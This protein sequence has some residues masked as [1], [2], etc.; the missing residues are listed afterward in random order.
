MDALIAAREKHLMLSGQPSRLL[1]NSVIMGNSHCLVQAHALNAQEVFSLR[2]ILQYAH[3]V[4][5][6]HT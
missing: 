2:K 5:L 3:N 4:Q 6:G 1:A